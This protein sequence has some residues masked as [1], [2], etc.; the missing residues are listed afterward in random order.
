MFGIPPHVYFVCALA[1]LLTGIAKAGFGG[2]V[3]V[4]AVPLMCLVMPSPAVAAAVLLPIL[5]L[6]DLFSIAYYRN[7]CDRRNLMLL[8]PGALFGILLGY[9]FFNSL[10]GHKEGL[11][12]GIGIITIAFVLFQVYREKI[13]Q[14]FSRFHPDWRHGLGFGTA[15]GFTSTLAHAAGPVAVIFLLPQKLERRLFVGTTIWFFTIVNAVKLIPYYFLNVLD[16]NNMRISLALAPL[17]PFGVILGIYLDRTISEKL[18]NR[19]IYTLTFLTGLE[20]VGVFKWM[21]HLAGRG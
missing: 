1:V 20:L 16:L 21:L 11:R 10:I 13:L 3:G 14:Q 17:V 7:V 2:G 9:L 18:F 6:C 15:A 4:A 12:I 5:C 19:V 8:L